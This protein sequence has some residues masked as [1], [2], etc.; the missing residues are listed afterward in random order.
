MNK[1][2]KF[3]NFIENNIINKKRSFVGE[4]FVNKN[5]KFKRSD[6]E[7]TKSE[8]Q[9]LILKIK[10]NSE[11][12]I[13]DDFIKWKEIIDANAFDESLK[14]IEA[15]PIN[16][17]IDHD[18]SIEGL[19]A[20]TQNG[21]MRV[22]KKD[23]GIYGII[24]AN[25]K[26][27]KL[28]K[29]FE[30]IKNG[31]VKS[32]SFIFLPIEIEYKDEVIDGEEIFTVIHKKA[33]L[34][35]IDPV[36]AGFYPFND[37]EVVDEKT[38]RKIGEKMNNKKEYKK[39]LELSKTRDLTKE[40]LKLKNKLEKL[41]LK[42]ALEKDDDDD[43][44]DEETIEAATIQTKDEEVE[45]PKEVEDQDFHDDEETP[46]G[47]TDEVEELKS[48]SESKEEVEKNDNE[49]SEKKS[50]TPPDIKL[51]KSQIVNLNFKSQTQ[52]QINLP[53][54]EEI[55]KMN[56]NDLLKKFLRSREAQKRELAPLIK[57]NVD[58]Y[59]NSLDAE[60]RNEI[61]QSIMHTANSNIFAERIDGS[62][63]TN[64][65][66]FISILNDPRVFTELEKILPEINGA[67]I[68][69]L[70][71]LD[72][73]KKDLLIPAATPINPIAEGADAIFVESETISI[74]FKP[75]RYSTEIRIN[76]K[77]ANAAETL[78]KETLNRRSSIV[79]S[80]RKTFYESLFKH[81][82]VAISTLISSTG[83]TYS[84]GITK[85]ALVPAL[86]VGKLTFQ[87]FDKIIDSI[88]STY[89]TD[90]ETHFSI[91]MHP[92]T[93]STILAQYNSS[94]TP[95]WNLF[96]RTKKTYRGIKIITANEYPYIL[97]TSSTTEPVILFVRKESIVIRGLNFV[98]ED[99]PYINQAKGLFTR[100]TTT[101]GEIKLIDPY[102]NTIGVT[103]P[104]TKKE[105]LGGKAAEVLGMDPK[106]KLEKEINN[107]NKQIES[108]SNSTKEKDIKKIEE[109]NKE[110]DLLIEELKKYN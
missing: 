35:S 73:V 56:Y 31:T 65:L 18:M 14:N 7:T 5:I 110:K 85:E 11:S 44:K 22:E 86:E 42:S 105:T 10:T 55:T 74:P 100:F 109:L 79:Q 87:D 37:C 68:I 80:I 21:S 53:K 59:L 17:Y 83:S 13:Q 54:K 66:A 106:S 62:N 71:T 108:R 41:I 51:T 24:P 57:N 49:E 47:K 25:L 19:I 72:E 99:N 1:K 84:G 107:I 8:N 50:E 28:M 94:G 30:W 9:E 46:D 34:L 63:Y 48:D 64:G 38:E 43:D 67:Q 93:Y 58:D 96:D 102:L 101:R 61:K 88:S 89:G 15:E 6:G 40:E 90:V 70:D 32:N 98:M 92:T 29:A 4:N 91:L 52:T 23:D 76:E 3:F 104:T 75:T 78:E 77:L 95:A 20:S 69:N 12:P 27:P 45:D 33:K 36:I 81:K 2:E 60:L 82:D 97:G 103:I 16:C 26:E 39:L